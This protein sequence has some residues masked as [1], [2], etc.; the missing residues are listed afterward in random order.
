MRN[1]KRLRCVLLLLLVA[2]LPAFAEKVSTLPA[3]AGY[4][5]D[6]ASVISTRTAVEMEAVCVELHEKT[7]AQ[8]FIVTVKTL[9]GE[10]IESFANEL[11]RKWKIGDRKNNRGVLILFAIDDHKDRIEVGYGLEPILNDAKVGDITREMVPELRGAHYDEAI[12]IG[13]RDVAT[14]IAADSGV[15]L[16]TLQPPQ[17]DPEP[18]IASPVVDT[19]APPRF[20]LF[21]KIAIGLFACLF[22]SIF[23]LM[24][25][26][27][28]KAMRKGTRSTLSSSDTPGSFSDDS[29]SSTSSS[30]SSSSDSSSSDSFSGGDGGDSGGGGASGS[31]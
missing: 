8:L 17:P 19:P 2:A 10:P 7:K 6:Y 12:S 3:P 29:G 15:M 11:F 20:P 5:D 21:A 18:T 31:W 4:V 9:E 25:W 24:G 30:D 16:D 22:G 23:F 28:I 27:A 14:I 26:F 13:L 1:L